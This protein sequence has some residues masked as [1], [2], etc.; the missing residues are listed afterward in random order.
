MVFQITG[1]A[2][3]AECDM[4]FSLDLGK[5]PEWND[6]I[7]T[8]WAWQKIYSL[9]GEYTRT[10]DVK[11]LDQRNAIAEQYKLKISYPKGQ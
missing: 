1:K 7:R 8:R 11:F 10:R 5:T 4:V 2:G 6:D 9:M 3:E